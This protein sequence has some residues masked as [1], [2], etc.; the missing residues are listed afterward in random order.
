MTSLQWMDDA[1]CRQIDAELFFPQPHTVP[2]D[3]KKACSLC[4]VRFPCLEYALTQNVEGVWGGTTPLER[5][6][7]KKGAA[8][9]KHLT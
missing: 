9:G 4:P 6:K 8:V 7:M 1:L 2:H 5:Q 3:A